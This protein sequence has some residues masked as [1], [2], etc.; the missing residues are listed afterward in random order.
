MPTKKT[1]GKINEK[2][3]KQELWQ[4]YNEVV[5]AITTETPIIVEDKTVNDTVKSLSETKLNINSE[6]DTLSKKLLADFD[7]LYKVKEQIRKGKDQMIENFEK[8]RIALANEIAEVRSK[9]TEEAAKLEENFKMNALE[10]EKQ[11]KR[12]GEE[13]KY[14]LELDRRKEKD[15]YEKQKMER[16]NI[17]KI[18]EDE[19]KARTD[20]IAEMEKTITVMPKKIEEEV[21]N[22]CAS[23]EKELTS[24]YQ[25][26]IKELKVT[27]DHEAKIS[28]IKIANL[29]SIIKS[30]TE[31]IIK[32][33]KQ[34]SS[35]N[36]LV[37]E[38]AVTAIESKGKTYANTKNTPGE[39]STK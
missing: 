25:S 14:N 6:F 5:S 21:K 4:A 16:E 30:Q 11:R 34:V 18:K 28:E 19:L 15:A 7:E 23:L 2:S 31:E 9:W 22:A 39:E 17:I 27:K 24:K 20:E 38:M 36:D 3:T 29:E 26:E 8:Q 1:D 10:I 12:E 35:S 13:Y 37:K 32:L 33:G